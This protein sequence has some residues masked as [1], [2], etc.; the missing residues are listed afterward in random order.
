M[1]ETVL[2]YK[3]INGRIFSTSAS[4]ESYNNVILHSCKRNLLF[5]LLGID[6]NFL[7]DYEK[8]VLIT[9]ILDAVITDHDK[10][11]GIV[12]LTENEIINILKTENDRKSL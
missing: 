5:K 2:A 9:K 10:V 4:C 7:F 3:S 12:N 1:I 6:R 8:Y 11:A